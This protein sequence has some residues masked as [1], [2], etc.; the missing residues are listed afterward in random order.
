MRHIFFT[1]LVGLMLCCSTSYAADKYDDAALREEARALLVRWMDTLLKYQLDGYGKDLDGGIICPACGRI[2]GR[3]GDAVLPLMYLADKTGDEKYLVA[4]KKLMIWMENIHRPDGSWMNDIHVSDW[5]GTTVFA[6]IALY[7]ALHYHG[8]LLDEETRRDWE[9]SLVRAG[10]FMMA[11]PA[12]FSRRM[13]GKMKRLNNVNYSASVTYA[14]Y[15]IGTA[16]GREDFVKEAQLVAEDMKSFFTA[17]D[18]FLFG[19]G[20]KIWSSTKNGCLPVDLGY[21]VEESLPAM[22]YY[23]MM[24]GDDELLG[25]VRKSMDTHLEFMLPDGAWDNS[26][27]T[28]SFKWTYWGGRTSD[29]FMGGYYSMAEQNP[30]YIEAIKRNIDLLEKSTVNGLL[31]AGGDYEAT[32]TPACIH[33][34]FG[35]AKALTA[36]LELKP[37]KVRK[38]GALPRDAEYGVKF[39]RDIRTYLISEGDWRATLTGFDAEYKV[40]GTHPMGG[41]VSLL[42]HRDLGPVFAATTNRYEL[43]EAPNM[44]SNAREYIMSGTPRVE[45]CQYGEIY[46]NLDDLDAEIIHDQT[47]G[48][49]MVQT[50]L[51][52]AEQQNPVQGSIEVK[53]NYGFSAEGLAMEVEHCP[54]SAHLLLPVI[55]SPGEKVE[56]SPKAARIYRNGKIL[57]VNCKHGRISTAACD[58]DGR[59][60]VPVPGF[61]FVPLQIVPEAGGKRIDVSISCK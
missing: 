55:S 36:M 22:A 35:H 14:L 57:T 20:P 17:N 21:N 4:A 27:G 46:S 37:A 50:H 40:K 38:S 33:H 58:R 29:G 56:I 12:M 26:W 48:K 42:W 3:I 5:A 45:M 31:N 10:E 15:A 25:L 51:V 6:A 2:H 7:E 8:H 41:A 34:T 60:F 32:G 44:Q 23:A 52:N 43:I 30:A 28:R 1:A 18:G 13:Q 61:A 59:I 19:E 11:N 49:F 54:Q 9:M 53:I 47:S 24:A 16:Y 39:F